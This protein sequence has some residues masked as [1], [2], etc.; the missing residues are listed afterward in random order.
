[1]DIE[2]QAASAK[3]SRL[4]AVQIPYIIVRHWLVIFVLLFGIFNVLPFLAPIAMRLGWTSGGEAIYAI[5][6]TMCHQMAQRSFFFLW[7]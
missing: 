7:C 1:M 5:Y 4:R 3:K 6:S 2:I